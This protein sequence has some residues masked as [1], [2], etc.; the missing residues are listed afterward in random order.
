MVTRFRAWLSKYRSKR[1]VAKEVQTAGILGMLSQVWFSFTSATHSG[2]SSCGIGNLCVVGT[3]ALRTL[4][5]V[6]MHPVNFTFETC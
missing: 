6:E 5:P 2:V 3:S 4:L 1:C